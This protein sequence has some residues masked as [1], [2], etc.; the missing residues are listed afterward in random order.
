MLLLSVGAT[1]IVPWWLGLQI[2]NAARMA[3]MRRDLLDLAAAV[4]AQADRRHPA[5]TVLRHELA[6]RRKLAS[7]P[8]R[9]VAQ[10]VF[11]FYRWF[12]W[13]DPVLDL[14]DQV[15]QALEFHQRSAADPASFAAEE[16]AHR[17]IPEWTVGQLDIS[18]KWLRSLQAEPPLWLRMRSDHASQTAAQIGNCTPV[19]GLPNAFRYAGA[20]DLFRRPE[21]HRGEFEIQDL[22]S[23][24]VSYLC[25]PRG[26]E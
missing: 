22:S 15:A 1:A 10:A 26:G 19:S 2:K 12:G 7:G 16:L 9:L 4:I 20:E 14:P 5:D 21:F 13:I 3:R 17:A 8:S 11:S 18:H 24:I 23:Q 25:S 6:G